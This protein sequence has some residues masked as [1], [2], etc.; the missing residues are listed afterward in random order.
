MKADTFLSKVTS[1]LKSGRYVQLGHPDITNHV[2]RLVENSPGPLIDATFIYHTYLERDSVALY[3]DHPSVMP[4][5]PEA[6]IGYRNNHGN[7]IVTFVASSP[8]DQK[9]ADNTGWTGVAAEAGNSLEE[10]HTRLDMWTFVGGQRGDGSMSPTA[11]PMALT[12]IAVAE[13]GR[14]LDVHWVDLMPGIVDQFHMKTAKKETTLRNDIDDWSMNSIRQSWQDEGW[15]RRE[16]GAIVRHVDAETW[17]WPR[18]TTMGVFTMLN[19]RNIELVESPLP[20]AAR[21]R[22][23]RYGVRSYVL[24]IQ[25]TGKRRRGGG[26]EAEPLTGSSTPLHSVRGHVRH[27]GACCGDDHPPRGKLFGR[28]TCKIWVPFHVRGSVEYGETEQTFVVTE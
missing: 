9:L 25:P 18:W 2:R 6:F 27:H 19:C 26:S 20:R 3:E 12:Q 5:W 16:D 11:G 13:S 7:A 17:D 1:E 24:A 8:W 28:L 10:A 15:P 23:E 4:P 21:R 14:P 22:E